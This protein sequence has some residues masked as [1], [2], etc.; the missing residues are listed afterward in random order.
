MSVTKKDLIILADKHKRVK[1]LME[2]ESW[3]YSVAFIMAGLAE[4]NSN[5][6]FTYYMKAAGVEPDDEKKIVVMYS[7]LRSK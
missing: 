6:K 4:C 2:I 7:L 1:S 5:F 3:K